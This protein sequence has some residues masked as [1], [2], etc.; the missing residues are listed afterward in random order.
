MNIT[1]STPDAS[2]GRQLRAARTRAFI[3]RDAELRAFRAA[4]TGRTDAFTVLYLHG[5]GGIGKSTLLQRFA[6]E[7]HQ[8]GRPVR[9][10]QPGPGDRPGHRPAGAD[11][12]PVIL[13]DALER[14]EQPEHWI[15]DTVLP[16]SPVGTLIVVAARRPPSV[17]WRADLGWNDVLLSLAV[18]PLAPAEAAD[19][20]RVHDVPAERRAA[21]L[22]FGAGNPLALRVTAQTIADVPAGHRDEDLYRE[23]ALAIYHQLIG[24][25]PT[26][27]HR[28]AL[29][30]SAHAAT[31]DEDLLRAAV[32][33]AD[34]AELFDWLQRLP[35]VASGARGLYPSDVVRNVVETEL[36]WRDSD[37]F[38]SMHGRVKEHLIR[39]A[40]TIADD[41]VIP[42]VA[43]VIF[44]QR[45]ES[46]Q[47][48]FFTRLSGFGVHEDRYIAADRDE[49]LQ[50]AR[51]A[52]GSESARLAEFWL[53]RQPEAFRVYRRLD[54]RTVIAF[55]ALLR[56]NHPTEE[57]LAEDPI[58]AAAWARTQN[59]MPLRPGEHLG[60]GRFA[61][62][63][64]AYHRPTEPMDLMQLR[65]AAAIMCDD[66]LTWSVI[67]TPDPEFW[68]PTIERSHEI[69]PE[70]PVP[71]GGRGYTL[72]AQHWGSMP[73]SAWSDLGDDQMLA[74]RQ[75]AA[76]GPL[77]STAWTRAE[78]D[79]AVRAT[80]RSWQRPDVLG[81]S[82]MAHSRM[83]AELG[84]S[85]PVAGLR[86]IFSAALETLRGDPRQAKFH[87]VLMATFFEGVPTQ[88]AA[89]ERLD[90]PYST[91][92]RHLA[93]GLDGLC[94]M[95]W[96]AET[97]GINF[98]EA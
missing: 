58:V 71:V 48:P 31:T 8:A 81:D 35:F 21:A 53:D 33:R 59:V 11:G 5:P 6:D 63:P 45:S 37:Q 87:R 13:I 42:F 1:D 93:R 92:R 67:V 49:V 30:V 68:A 12:P 88:E 29:E 85:D 61:I 50:I 55:S 98:L 22:E 84:G 27:A 36:R 62:D 95:L 66:D 44:V 75:P 28:H 51:Q 16:D 15:R 24:D 43:D 82:R 80:L 72:Y 7:A 18:A 41:A 83:V 17:D 14:W 69:V 78:F 57:E 94:A 9:R 26:R 34:A 64:A 70:P 91:Y 25:V 54:D 2:L 3:G 19:L 23:V 20:L 86:R 96:K 38:A 4:L 74:R 40:R 47:R 77:R 73:I 10:L 56:V 46:R 39:R 60:I 65:M 79:Q 32:P 90:L 52:E 89:A 97:H 76:A